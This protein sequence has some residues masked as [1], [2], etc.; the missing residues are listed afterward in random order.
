MVASSMISCRIALIFRARTVP[1]EYLLSDNRPQDR[2]RH[3]RGR[4]HEVLDLDGTT[5]SSVNPPSVESS[6]AYRT[7][8]STTSSAARSSAHAAA[9]CGLEEGNRVLESLEI[10]L[11][12]LRSAPR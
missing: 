6:G 4:D 9:T 1:I 3:L 7:S 12:A 2:R 10:E 5:S 11:E 8:A